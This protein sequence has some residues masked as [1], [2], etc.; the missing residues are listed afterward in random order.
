MVHTASSFAFQGQQPRGQ[1]GLMAENVNG[2]TG[3]VKRV[4]KSVSKKLGLGD[5]RATV[6][7]PKSRSQEDKMAEKYAQI[8]DVQEV[9]FQV[10]LDLGLIKETKKGPAKKL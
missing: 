7:E 1:K 6:I 5:K 2:E 8:D 3:R 9:A 4:L 10:L